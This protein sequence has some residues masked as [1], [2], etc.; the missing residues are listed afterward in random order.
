MPH[1]SASFVGP[2][3]HSLWTHLL[4]TLSHQLPGGEGLLPRGS[5]ACGSPALQE[6]QHPG[7]QAPQQADGDLPV[8][9]TLH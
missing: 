2:S 1:L 3:G 7:P 9:R 6:I 5:P 8:H 4:H